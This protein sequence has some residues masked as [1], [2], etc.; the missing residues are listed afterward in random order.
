MV[1]GKKNFREGEQQTSVF[2]TDRFCQVNGGWYF[3]TREQTQ[4]G[5]FPSKNVA[6]S[7]AEDYVQQKNLGS[8][9]RR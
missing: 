3:I 6:H 2:R 7:A 9:P 5:P 1:L 4:E 8:S